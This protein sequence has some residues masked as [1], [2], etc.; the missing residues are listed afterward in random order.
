M[1]EL[2]ASLGTGEGTWEHLRRLINQQDWEKVILI[3]N[4][5]KKK[6]FKSEKP[7]EFILIDEKKYLTELSEE[8]KD[9]LKDKITG[10]EVAV[11]I[12]SGTGKEHMALLSALLKLGLA[13]RFVALTKDGVKEI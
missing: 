4:D 7:V 1:T 9:K 5:L 8:I 2:I 13:M 3:T 10:I 11:S 12:I 6:N